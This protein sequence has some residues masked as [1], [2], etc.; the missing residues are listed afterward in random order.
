LCPTFY[1]EQRLMSSKSDLLEKRLI[2]FGVG[3]CKLV[4]KIEND[5]VR[6]SEICA[7]PSIWSN[8]SCHRNQT[9]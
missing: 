1:L 4:R 7:Q 5:I 6:T 9:S 3:A 8:V 2:D